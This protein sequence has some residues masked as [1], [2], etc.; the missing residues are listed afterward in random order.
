MQDNS[1]SEAS[2]EIWR[3]TGTGVFAYLNKTGA[4]ATTYTDTAVTSGVT[5]RYEARACT[6]TLCSGFS[7]IATVKVK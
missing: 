5:Y 3:A 4:N 6:T 1:N 2:V 7:N